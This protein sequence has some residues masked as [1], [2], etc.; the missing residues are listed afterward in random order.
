MHERGYARHEGACIRVFWRLDRLSWPMDG[1][2]GVVGEA[3]DGGA[4]AFV[5]GPSP[6][7]AAVWSALLC[8]GSDASLGGEM[9]LALRRARRPVRR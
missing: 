3:S 2:P 4:Q 6:A 8:D 5:A 1:V 9:I 7:N